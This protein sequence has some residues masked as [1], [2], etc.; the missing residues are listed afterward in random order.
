MKRSIWCAVLL[1]GT[2]T[3]LRAQKVVSLESRT[4]RA[5]F[6]CS[7]AS[8]RLLDK[9]TGVVWTIEPP[10][11]VMSDESILSVR[12]TGE[13]ALAGNVLRFSSEPRLEIQLRVLEDPSAL[14]YSFRGGAQSFT[15]PGADIDEVRLL[16]GSLAIEPGEGNYYAIPSRLGVLLPAEGDKPFRRR[17][18]AFGWIQ[19]YSMAM[20]GVVKNGSALMVAW[21][22]PYTDLIL[23][24]SVEPRRQLTAGLALRETARTVRF[25]PLGRGGYVEVAKA[26]RRIARERG[27]WKPLADKL[28]E[29]PAVERLIGAADFKPFVFNRLLPNTQWNPTDKD[30]LHVNMSFEEAARLAKHYRND[31]GIDRAMLVLAGWIRRGY[32]NQHPDILPAAPELGGNEALGACSRRVKALGWLFGLHDNYQDMYGDAPSWNED[33]IVKNPDGSLF[34]GGQWYGGPCWII[35]PK[36]SLELVARP[37]NFPRVRELFAP[38]VYF[39]DCVFA[40][41]LRWCFDPRHPVTKVDDMRYKQELADYIGKQSVLFGSEEGFEYGVAQS[42]YFEGMMSQKTRP[43]E[44]GSDI[45]IPLFELVF[46]DAIPL[47]AHQGDLVRPDNSAYILAHI[48][49]A[50]MPVYDFGGRRYLT[51]AFG[52]YKPEQGSDP[53]LVFTRGGRFG[54]ADQFIK[55]TYEVLSPLVRTT[56]LLPMTDHSFLTPDRG[57][58]ATRFGSDVE[59]TVNFGPADYAV[60]DAVL[61][62]YGFLVKSPALV[63]FCARRYM[64]VTYPE[65]TMFVVRSLDGQPL[66]SSSKV[67]I[68]RGFGD[69]RIEWNGQILDVKTEKIVSGRGSHGT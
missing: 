31:L 56:A 20:M 27:Y 36:K 43:G 18:N 57:V 46:G 23:E 67:R 58:E 17:M 28:R 7:D 65:A 47:Y 15:S 37:Q 40:N 1:L 12:P 69:R 4:F 33:D 64:G 24:Y 68:Y 8:I 30:V 14:E 59:I 6:Q 19:G 54:P 11:V 41:P 25:Q 62:Q 52:D 50:E 2:S 38:D 45:I 53:G 35:C 22:A 55:N 32:D 60:P 42:H 10:Q 26:Y 21:D 48:L 5:D 44:R 3:V 51:E 29:N 39:I 16:Q 13:V 49:Y 9:D 66:S 63:A 34:S 61:P